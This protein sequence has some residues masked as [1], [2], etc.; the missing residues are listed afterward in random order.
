MSS[1][2]KEPSFGEL[3]KEWRVRAGKTQA[4]LDAALD[5][6]LGYTSQLEGG[7]IKKP[8]DRP[9]CELIAQA[10]GVSRHEVW[11]HAARARL[12]EFDPE[13]LAF[14]DDEIARTSGVSAIELSDHERALVDACR[15]F[16]RHTS[17]VTAALCRMLDDATAEPGRAPP[18][19]QRTAAQITELDMNAIETVMAV[20]QS[21]V[22]GLARHRKDR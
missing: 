2:K 13:L 6:R 20:L 3:L 17:I 19:F 4:E 1:K 22:D 11:A 15:R 10:L 14:H 16:G 7:Y 18:P 21:V 8:P 5:K 12:R 9:T